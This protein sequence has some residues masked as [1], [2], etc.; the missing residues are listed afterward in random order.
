[1]RSDVARLEAELLARWSRETLAAY[2]AALR[3]AGDPRGALIE[4]DLDDG[5]PD[6]KA[7]LEAEWLGDEVAAQVSTRYGFV[8][9]CFD[10]ATVLPALDRIAPYARGLSLDGEAPDVVE[11]LAVIAE[12]SRPWLGTL[13]LVQLDARSVP[14]VDDTL[15]AQVITAAPH[16]RKL[17]VRGHRV[18]GGFPHPAVERVIADGHDAIGA[19]LGTG[20]LPRVDTLDLA[21]HPDDEI[22]REPSLDELRALLPAHALPQ[23]RTL[24][25]SRNEPRDSPLVPNCL[26]GKTPIFEVLAR[27]GV[28][29]QLVQLR[30]PSLRT[31][32]HREQLQAALDRMPS[33]RALEVA[34]MYVKARVPLAHPHAR[35]TIARPSPWQAGDAIGEYDALVFDDIDGARVR[36][37]LERAYEVVE[38]AELDVTERA[39]WGALWSA[40]VEL[41]DDYD[42]VEKLARRDLEIVL[43]TF[44]ED[45][46]TSWAELRDRIAET[47]ARKLRVRRVEGYEADD[48]SDD[49]AEEEELDDEHALPPSLHVI[50]T[51]DRI[52]EL[53]HELQ[54]TW[55]PE[56][57]V[58]YA[59]ELQQLGDPRGELIALD[60]ELE[61][62][63]RPELATRRAALHEQVFG[64]SGW[65]TS[66]LGFAAFDLNSWSDNDEELARFLAL[67]T[68]RYLAT[69]ELAGYEERLVG[70]IERLTA[71][72]RPWLRKAIV[73]PLGAVTARI[74]GERLVKAWP[75]LREL[76]LSS[77]DPT[78][79]FAALTHPGVR[80]MRITGWRAFEGLG[81]PWPALAELD[82]A[83]GVGPAPADPVG[84]LGDAG[85]LPALR[86]L[87]LSRNEP[88]SLD[89]PLDPR[90]DRFQGGERD[91]FE[92]VPRYDARVL[93]NLVE[94]RLPSP[95]TRQ[96][97]RA[98]QTVLDATPALE[99]LV[100]AR[101]YP[102]A[103]AIELHH[104]RAQLAIPAP[105]AWPPLDATAEEAMLV[106]AGVWVPVAPLL[107]GME[108][109]HDRLPAD[110]RELWNEI[111]DLFRNTNR[112][113]DIAA[114]K[115]HRAAE[116]LAVLDDEDLGFLQELV[117][118]LRGPAIAEHTVTV[119]H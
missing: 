4:L 86:V 63:R 79:L 110:A 41:V 29:P 72:V 43:A 119:T 59:D 27:C 13:E 47:G 104:R 40:A 51:S 90:G 111:W 39:A 114:A 16:L 94:L 60:L 15:A 76:N 46:D 108:R 19:L 80:S 55:D 44:P 67:E 32:D 1:M 22:D 38:T 97:V 118:V 112:R 8:E 103:P 95:R 64:P 70:A 113:F 109:H 14:L 34:R 24:D 69:V 30:V 20:V 56:R 50:A 28:L 84:Y 93:A 25:V 2:G 71:E 35:I 91:I 96:H 98:I 83:Y 7:D 105:C 87:D 89:A 116:V 26:G 99:R 37:E 9:D 57:L 31:V 65:V 68:A 62:E 45:E 74:D 75:N 82:L 115:L 11:A 33:L 101:V 88:P 78:E 3:A 92:I 61:R 49:D 107:Q 54:E 117:D 12:A 77:A 23:L 5:D 21:I 81:A 102:G 66:K 17:L 58:V 106:I 6:D 73:Y 36:V 10:L 100:I 52:A 18:I 85:A 48:V 42:R 53:E